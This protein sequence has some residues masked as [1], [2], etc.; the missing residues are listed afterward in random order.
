M[1]VLK[2]FNIKIDRFAHGLEFL[3]HITFF[4][5]IFSGYLHALQFTSVTIEKI[6]N[7]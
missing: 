3:D 7:A 5:E 6:Q 2:Y 4:E 1:I